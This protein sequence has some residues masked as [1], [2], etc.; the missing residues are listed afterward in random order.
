MRPER[1]TTGLTAADFS[2]DP[3]IVGPR[4]CG[5]SRYNRRI[6]RAVLG[7]RLW[8]VCAVVAAIRVGTCQTTTAVVN[9]YCGGC[10]NEKA[11]IGGLAL[12][13]DHIADRPAAW[14]KAVRKLRARYMP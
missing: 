7:M 11:R 13:A 14:E 10:H 4:R 12:D 6:A 1:P 9:Q 2:V 3:M 5:G 8:M